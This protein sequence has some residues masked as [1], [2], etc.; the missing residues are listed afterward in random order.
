MKKVEAVFFDIDSTILQKS[1]GE[2]FLLEAIKQKAIP[3]SIA[4]RIPSFI[5]SYYFGNP[6]L[7]NYIGF[8]PQIKTLTKDQIKQISIDCFDKYKTKIYPEIYKIIKTYKTQNIPV[9]LATSSIDLLIEPIKNYLEIT[10]TISSVLEFSLIDSKPTGKFIDRPAF[11]KDKMLKVLE[12]C[13]KENINIK[14]CAFYSD[15]YHDLPL[16]EEVGLPIV[17]NPDHR[18]LAIAKKRQW[19]IIKAKLLH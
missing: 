2:Y 7:D 16:L 8:F 3:L 6:D 13:K 10:S 5:L 19:Q 11:G 12:F 4:L 17:V 1:T 18:L 9:F 15:S 14:E